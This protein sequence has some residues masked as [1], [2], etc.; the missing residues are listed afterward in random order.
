MSSGIVGNV[1][2]HRSKKKQ[3]TP[4]ICFLTDLKLWFSQSRIAVSEP[5]VILT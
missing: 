4:R 2:L 5:M 3:Q 1:I